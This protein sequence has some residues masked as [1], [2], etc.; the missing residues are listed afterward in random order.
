MR[1]RDLI[2]G[3][4]WLVIAIVVLGLLI[5]GPKKIPEL[6]RSIGEARGEFE[7][8]SKEAMSTV[9]EASEKKTKPSSDDELIEIAKKLGISTEGKTREQISNEIMEKLKTEKQ[10]GA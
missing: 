2:S 9:S 4:E 1:Y 8:A 6:A 5:W 10:T 3:W 7:K